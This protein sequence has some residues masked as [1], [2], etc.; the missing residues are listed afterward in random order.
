M[1]SRE[2]ERSWVLDYGLSS[3][4]S[5]DVDEDDA[6]EQSMMQ[7][8]DGIL[9]AYEDEQL[10]GWDHWSGRKLRPDELDDE[11]W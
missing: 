11:D 6:F 10:A 9:D 4:S 7:S 2:R 1:Q 8:W 3:A 5:S